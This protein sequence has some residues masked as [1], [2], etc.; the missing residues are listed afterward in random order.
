MQET[1]N[2]PVHEYGR[3]T[4][5]SIE[6]LWQELCSGESTLEEGA[7]GGGLLRSVAVVTV[8]ICNGKGEVHFQP[9]HSS[10]QMGI[11]HFKMPCLQIGIC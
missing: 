8:L 5:K 7:H 11:R 10:L 6:Q 9:T 4:T 1:K 2:L 3:G